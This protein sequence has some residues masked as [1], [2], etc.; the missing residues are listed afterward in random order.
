MSTRAKKRKRSAHAPK[1]AAAATAS[2]ASTPL[3]FAASS[4]AESILAVIRARARL[5][6]TWLG[7]VWSGEQEMASRPDFVRASEV[8]TA[9]DDRDAPQAERRWAAGH[10][11]VQS[12]LAA[13]RATEDALVADGTSR[14]VQLAERFGLELSDLHVVMTCLAL[15]V[16]PSLARVYAYL[17]DSADRAY[18]TPELVAR[19]FGHGRTTQISSES[20]LRLWGLV[21]ERDAAPGEP[22][23][24][25]LDP[26][27]RDWLVGRDELDRCLVS[28]ARLVPAPP[29][30]P[31]WPISGTL[32]RLRRPV[33]QGQSTRMRVVILG[34]EGS[35]R[36]S[37]AACIAE[38]LGLGL[39]AIDADAIDDAEWPV[40]WARAQRQAFLGACA[41]MWHGDRA[42][43]AF[44]H[45]SRALPPFPVQFIATDAT[46]APPAWPGIFDL[47]V[48][49]PVPSLAERRALW[50]GLVPSAETWPEDELEALAITHRVHVGEIVDAARKGLASAEEAARGVRE[51]ARGRIETL[52][53]RLDTPFRWADLVVGDGVR[54]ALEDLV[55][56]A[57]DRVTFWE[58]PAARRMFPQGQGLVALFT[59]LPG[60]G[61]TMAAQVIANALGVDL[62][63]IDL[64]AVVSKYVGETS[65]NLERVLVAAARMDVV[66]LFDE[67]DALFGKRVAIE[68]AQDRFANTDTNHL[69]QAIESYR[70]VAV[71]ASNRKAN[72]DPAFTRRIR[73]I[74][75]FSAPDATQRLAIWRSV[76][77]EL[78][79]GAGPG[80]D[81]A[82]V[83]LADS[84]EVTGAQIKSSLLHA[85]FAA[86]REKTAL[87][88]RHLLRGLERELMK[89]GRTLGARQKERVAAHVV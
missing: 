87:S 47:V 30:L 80:L 82:L 8:V 66:L 21:A 64:S 50:R 78:A 43:R 70:G 56:E 76:T 59:G 68:D 12:S 67:A 88:A 53:Q 24:L 31:S 57:K 55:F 73:Y 35:G 42:G 46:S 9:L 45:A 23:A 10:P 52:A 63:R 36:R 33:A 18:V 19:L 84:V 83:S 77:S 51:S 25:E 65:K 61:K 85:F 14:L 29:A 15:D 20:S 2:P 49:M 69:L 28:A 13:I 41:L 44:G 17:Q 75:D 40:V 54:D 71:L 74:L 37:F 48:Q 27:V 11:E 79:N 58:K 62:F 22:R 1:Q 16:D 81:P 7:T 60:T 34:S 6:R 32:E 3:P 86:R 5:R 39:L 38:E 4:L 72:I 26:L 89:D